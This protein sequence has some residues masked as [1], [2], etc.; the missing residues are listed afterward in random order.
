MRLNFRTSS[1]GHFN[2]F[3]A[4]SDGDGF[5]I[6]RMLMRKLVD[7]IDLRFNDKGIYVLIIDGPF[8]TRLTFIGQNRPRRSTWALRY[9]GTRST[10]L[11]S[12]LLILTIETVSIFK[13]K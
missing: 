2:C 8:V 3:G 13:E 7:K 5:R 4:Y 11:H 6:N 10:V 9:M 1:S 12:G